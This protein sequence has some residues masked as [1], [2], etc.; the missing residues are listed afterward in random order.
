MNLRDYSRRDFVRMS[1]ASAFGVVAC[2]ALGSL[3]A[4]ELGD[5]D[6]DLPSY[7][8]VS[9]GGFGSFGAG[10]L[11]PQFAPMAVSGI[12]DNPNSRANLTID[13]LKPD[14]PV[15][16]SDQEVRRKLLDELQGD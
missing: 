6:A 3:F 12:S 10:F 11:G 9:P 5:P 16:A 13:F 2:P 8:T 14:K 7:V 4:K 1:L 15:A